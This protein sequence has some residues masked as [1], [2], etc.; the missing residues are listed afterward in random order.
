MVLTPS[1][2]QVGVD[3]QHLLAKVEASDQVVHSHLDYLLIME[4]TLPFPPQDGSFNRTDSADP[5]RKQITIGHRVLL[6]PQLLL[7][8]SGT[9]PSPPEH[10][11]VPHS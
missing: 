10:L 6:I 11:M 5:V 7:E 1:I 8:Q 3:L 9:G 4:Q 2:K